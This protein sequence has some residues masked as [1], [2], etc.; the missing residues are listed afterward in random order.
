MLLM[1]EVLVGVAS[2]AILT[3]EVFGLREFTGATL[4]IAAAVVEVLR[5]QKFDKSGIV[6]DH[7]PP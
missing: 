5:Q 7:T 1:V 2:A 6:S 4:I 3:D